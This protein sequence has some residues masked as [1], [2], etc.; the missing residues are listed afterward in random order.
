MAE[1]T[2]SEQC[3][4]QRD[5][6]QFQSNQTGTNKL[7]K[8][9]VKLKEEEG[10]LSVQYP[11]IWMPPKGPLQYLPAALAMA[12]GLGS[13]AL[14]IV[15][16]V[17]LGPD[18]PSSL[19]VS[20]VLL[21]TVLLAASLCELFHLEFVHELNFCSTLFI[22]GG[23]VVS[24]V[25]PGG[26]LSAVVASMVTT[27]GV[28]V[29]ALTAFVGS[30]WQYMVGSCFL[31]LGLV[32][33]TSATTLR[34]ASGGSVAEQVDATAVPFI[35]LALAFVGAKSFM[36]MRRPWLSFPNYMFYGIWLFGAGVV[37]HGALAVFVLL[38]G[39]DPHEGL[40]RVARLLTLFGT[41]LFVLRS[42]RVAFHMDTVIEDRYPMT[43]HFL[44]SSIAV[45]LVAGSTV[46][47]FCVSM[48]AAVGAGLAEHAPWLVHAM[49]GADAISALAFA[50]ISMAFVLA[51]PPIGAAFQSL[52]AFALSLGV[53]AA[54]VAGIAEWPMVAIMGSAAGCAGGIGLAL[55]A[56]RNSQHGADVRWAP[57]TWLRVLHPANY[58]L[59]ASL[60]FVAG[61]G[62]RVGTGLFGEDSARWLYS[63]AMGAQ[64][65]GAAVLRLHV[66]MC[67]DV[68]ESTELSELFDSGDQQDAPLGVVQDA[69]EVVD[70]IISGA[71]PAGLA[72]ACIL[73][74]AGVRTLVLE[75]RH[76]IVTDARFAVVN[77][78]SME[79]LLDVLDDDLL[80]ELRARAMP[81]S[82][83][84]GSM[85]VNGLGHEDAKV[86]NAANSPP[87]ERLM[88]RLAEM[89][90]W[91]ESRTLGSRHARELP[92]RVMQSHQEA[93]L[94]KQ[95]ERLDSV[96]VL[97]GHELVDFHEFSAQD[98]AGV[99]ARYRQSVDE[100]A[101]GCAQEPLEVSL[102]TKSVV[103]QYIVGAD[104]P[105]STVAKKMGFSFDGFINLARPRSILVKSD[106]LY[107]R[108]LR[109]VGA[110]YQYQIIRK[111]WGIA[112]V[113]AADP[114]R[115]M[116]N[117]LML[118]GD[119]VKRATA[120]ELA[121]EFL[122]VEDAEVIQDRSWYWNFFVARDFMK[123]RVL[124]VGDSAHSWPPFGGLGGNGAYGDAHNLGW[125]LALAC[126]GSAGP[127][128]LRSYSVERRQAALKT[129]LHVLRAAPRP[130]LMKHLVSPVFEWPLIRRWIAAGWYF[131]NSGAHGHNHF[132][133]SG[134]QLG[135]KLNFSPAVA[136]ELDPSADDPICTY[137]PR[138]LA[139]CRVPD[140]PLETGSRILDH[141]ARG[142]FTVFVVRGADDSS[143]SKAACLCRMMEGGGVLARMVILPAFR[144]TPESEAVRA[145]Y[146]HHSLVV[147]RPDFYIAW[148]LP[149]GQQLGDAELEDVAATLLGAAPGPGA[150]C[151]QLDAYQRWLTRLFLF[152]L[153]PFGFNF[154]SA[155]PVANC[156]KEEAKAMVKTLDV[157]FSTSTKQAGNEKTKKLE[158]D[159]IGAKIVR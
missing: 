150:R 148:R 19:T 77:S 154:P 12:G 101:T 18:L 30:P 97:Y 9:A 133:Q 153:R 155:V 15:E 129:A 152:N 86:L 56:G 47:L 65:L 114:A 31:S 144:A 89:D 63:I 84:F 16:A 93:V 112:G 125:K 106:S 137:H 25:V 66:S 119:R 126:S 23:A 120:D 138:V 115:G 145:D 109:T 26:G 10:H 6:H 45:R 127:Q 59:L 94:R 50:C 3:P 90:S 37:T 60:Y 32:L 62:L 143:A 36:Q 2:P 34:W 11:P 85:L 13:L 135:M 76:R 100:E 28:F 158:F 105:G 42:S 88:E 131:H 80:S 55:F 130:Q 74:K 124:L 52:A 44:P 53:A 49:C 121:R 108:V 61:Q 33:R 14:L 107:E 147:V 136:A 156:T 7:L 4:A 118:F 8:S 142:R 22:H 48:S 159:H 102:S 87:R 140:A 81:E 91:T 71:G 151:A 1:D 35:L 21:A 20:A 58:V 111:N 46:V 146:S 27:I 116:W 157:Q 110:T 132:C 40:G 73:G 95:A 96:K 149:R 128:L 51:R 24:A 43:V 79:V 122:G 103:A 57:G 54:G 113:V 141:V 82:C 134:V 78:A 98:K 99:A 92:I 17:D 104:G 5:W 75:K 39:D 139:G 83:P 69:D 67:Q 38:S 64:A 70:V 123:G 41:L 72:T 29:F 68:L 117:F